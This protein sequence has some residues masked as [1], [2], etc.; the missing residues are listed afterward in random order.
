MT[1]WK[2]PK[3]ADMEPGVLYCPQM[4]VDGVREIDAKGTRFARVRECKNLADHKGLK[5]FV[6]SECG[7]HYLGFS[8]NYCPNCGGK[9]RRG[10]DD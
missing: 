7:A 3:R 8:F 2:L 6:C 1:E 5:E 10:G 9:L 4:D